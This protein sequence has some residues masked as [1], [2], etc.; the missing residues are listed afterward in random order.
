MNSV[1]YSIATKIGNPGLGTVSYNAVKALNEKG[2]L[3][4]AVSYMNKTDLPKEKIITLYGNPAKLLFF[5][6]KR[7]YRPLRKI[8]FDY[9]TSKIISKK[10]CEVFHGWNSQALRSIKSAHK[11]GAKAII[12]CGSTHRLYKDEILM[13][14]YSRSGM[15]MDKGPQYAR[16]GLLEEI[17]LADYIFLTSEF[18]KK[19]FVKAGVKEEKLFVIERGADLSRFSPGKPDND[20]FRVLFV[21]RISLRKG[22]R[23]LLEAWKSLGLKNAEL[24]MV[25]GIDDSAKPLIAQYAGDRTIK[26]TGF[27]K[28]TSAEYK[29][30]HIFVFP[31]IEEGSA[32]VTF[33][34]MASGLPVITTANSGSIVR[35]SIDGFI[36]PVAE[37]G[38]IKDKILYFYENPEKVRTM[39]SSASENARPYTWERYSNKLINTYEKLFG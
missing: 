35:D 21:G 20:I 7:H 11:I 12:E 2:I 5:L 6:P 8:Y 31:S 13:N 30:S 22:V 24:V 14:E 1:I 19:T 36:I 28:N 37:T 26:F 16:K 39:G 29:K 34:A 17:D 15:E 38:P 9:I 27:I 23:Y 4:V 3:S 10:G 33:E 25:G 18:A 32:K